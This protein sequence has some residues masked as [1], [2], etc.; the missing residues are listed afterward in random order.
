MTTTSN[1]YS[2]TL[3]AT[4]SILFFVGFSAAAAA[5]FNPDN[6]FEEIGTDASFSISGETDNPNS[7]VVGFTSTTESTKSTSE[8]FTKDT[9]STGTQTV[10]VSNTPIADTNSD[11]AIDGNDITVTATDATVSFS[12][13]NPKTGEVTYNVDT[14]GSTS[15][16]TV[17]VEYDYY[18]EAN[19]GIDVTSGTATTTVPTSDGSPSEDGTVQTSDGDT[20]TAYYWDSSENTYTTATTDADDNPTF[21]SASVSDDTPTEV[22]VTFSEDVSLTS[23]TSTDGFSVSGVSGSLTGASAS[24]S[25]VTLTLDSP[26]QT[27]DTVT[28]SYDGTTN[29]NVK[30]ADEGN[31]EAQTFTDN[32]VNNNVDAPTFATDYPTTQSIGTSSFDVAA[33]M[34]DETADVYYVVVDDGDS[35]PTTTEV[36][37]GES[38]GGG[39]PIA[40]GS[41]TGVSTAG[42]STDTVSGLS[43]GTAYDVYFVAEDDGGVEQTATTAVDET[44][45]SVTD[46][47]DSVDWIDAAQTKT[48]QNIK[49]TDDDADSTDTTL[50]SFTITNSGDAT[51]DQV[52]S[53]T[54]SD[55]GGEVASKSTFDSGDLGS[56]VT[57]TPTSETI[58][59][60]G[61]SSVSETYSVEVTLKSRSAVTDANTFDLSTD[62]QY[63][64]DETRTV[65]ADD[66]STEEIDL[67]PEIT[68]ATTADSNNNGQIDQVKVDFSEA[69]NVGSAFD[70]VTGLS[71]GTAGEYTIDELD[72]SNDQSSLTFSVD[73]SGS[74]DTG[75][76]PD[77]EYNTGNSELTDSDQQN[78]EIAAHGPT[79]ATD[80]A[81]PVATSAAYRDSNNDGTVDKVDIDFSETVDYTA[82]NTPSDDWSI[83]PNGVTN[84]AVESTQVSST[85]NGVSTV[86]VDVTADSDITGTASNEPTIDYG[87]SGDNGVFDQASSS[88]EAVS[89]SPVTATDEAAPSFKSVTT[90][91]SEPNGKLDGLTVE[92]TE[93]VADD[94]VETADLSIES[95]NGLSGSIAGVSGNGDSDSTVTVDLS[96]GISTDTGATPTLDYSEDG[97]NAAI[98]DSSSNEMADQPS[99]AA[100]D[101][102]A[103]VLMNS[104]IDHD[105][106]TSSVT[107]VDLKFSETIGTGTGD[108]LTDQTDVALNVGS[109]PSSD[110]VTATAEESGTDTVLQTGDSP[111]VTDASVLGDGQSNSAELFESSNVQIDTFRKDLSSGWNFVSFPIADSTSPSLDSVLDM[112]KVDVVWEYDSDGWTSSNDDLST[113]EAGQGYLVNASSDHTIAPNVNNVVSNEG[114]QVSSPGEFELQAGWNLVGQYQEFNQDADAESNDQAAFRT[115]GSSNF[116]TVYRQTSPG[117][118]AGITDV[119]GNSGVMKTGEAFWVQTTGKIP[120]GSL[121]YSEN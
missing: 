41:M 88:N 113:V 65:T 49:L 111:K 26:V 95:A 22:D 9:T 45:D 38:S 30:D 55:S 3:I 7:A 23:G 57:L 75:A 112:D 51:I 40:S 97:S 84:L 1:K 39:S 73:E 24:G 107:Q 70:G 74:S 79:A 61:D 36:F 35:S 85:Q 46:D 10:T 63:T 106:S 54:I 32:S 80:G 52:Q 14:S 100:A 21:S 56:G 5:S 103:P 93:A 12:S 15:S 86:T 121:V 94:S 101:T 81:A 29:G 119:G 20:I 58:S 117:N 42:E 37:N 31:F 34:S 109:S 17:T 78:K 18:P 4:L 108:V 105:G 96:E 104:E 33:Q 69:V 76:T 60:G 82:S 66:S 91:D 90:V 98:Q 25:T 77:V 115:V 48:V 53:I 64:E 50:D 62:V 89:S 71:I 92:F 44:A 118:L 110:V 47:G 116:N 11:V 114:A 99:D 67:T 13:A 59:D 8:D 16:D 2:K 120:A 102:S 87:Q 43:A 72:S 19:T 28:V 27:D 68:G 6:A 83:T